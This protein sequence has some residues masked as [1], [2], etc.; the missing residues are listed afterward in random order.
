MGSG[1]IDGMDW[2]AANARFP[3]V[4]SMSLGGGASLSVDIAVRNLVNAGVTVSVASGSSDVRA[5]FSNYGSCVDIFAPGVDITSTWKGRSNSAT[6]TISG[7]SMACPHVSGVA[8][9]I[10]GQNPSLTPDEVV[11]QILSDATSGRVINKG[12]L[13]PDLLLY[14][15]L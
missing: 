11:A 2:V 14:T 15:P 13:S 4:A 5:S 6:T 12:T 10:L 9:L 8:A 1:I 7:T 3:A